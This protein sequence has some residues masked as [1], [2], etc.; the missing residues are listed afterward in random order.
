MLCRVKLRENMNGK[1]R[2][3]MP[4]PSSESQEAEQK[5]GIDD[6]TGFLKRE[7]ILRDLFSFAPP[8]PWCRNLAPSQVYGLIPIRLQMLME[9]T[10]GSVR[11]KKE[12]CERTRPRVESETLQLAKV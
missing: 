1:D 8:G 9:T 5:K 6:V 4:N 3:V 7:K 12:I 11:T 2:Y 10:T